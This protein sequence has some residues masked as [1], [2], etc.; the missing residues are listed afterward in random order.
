VKWPQVSCTEGRQLKESRHARQKQLSEN[1][2]SEEWM[3]DLR[4]RNFVSIQSKKF[5]TVTCL[6]FP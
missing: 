4:S 1:S 2:L 5:E 6:L 3:F